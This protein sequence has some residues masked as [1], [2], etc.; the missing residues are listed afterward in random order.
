VFAVG[1]T[2]ALHFDQAFWWFDSPPRTCRLL[3]RPRYALVTPDGSLAERVPRGIYL[4]NAVSSRCASRTPAFCNC[5]R[6]IGAFAT[7]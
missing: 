5:S 3:T 4:P 1:H 2:F 6:I 7:T